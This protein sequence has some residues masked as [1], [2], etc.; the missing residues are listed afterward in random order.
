[1]KEFE[2]IDV[3]IPDERGRAYMKVIYNACLHAIQDMAGKLERQE[4]NTD[5][6]LMLYVPDEWINIFKYYALKFYYNEE[7]D[8]LNIVLVYISLSDDIS[9]DMPLCSVNVSGSRIMSYDC[10]CAAYI[11]MTALINHVG[12]TENLLKEAIMNEHQEE[13]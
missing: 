13:S 9:N 4:E 12:L 5:A 6:V 11:F 2:Q 7:F 10:D 1:M 8:L 3:Y